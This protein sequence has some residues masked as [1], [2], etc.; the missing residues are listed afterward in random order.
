MIEN[1]PIEKFLYHRGGMMLIDKLLSYTKD[2]VVVEACITRDSIFWQ[3]DG[4]PAVIGIEYA[5]Q[6]VATLSGVRAVLNNEAVKLGLL[7]SGRRYRCKK[8]YFAE[9][10][11]LTIQAIESFNDGRMGAYNCKIMGPDGEEIA[12]VLIN[13]YVPDSLD[14]LR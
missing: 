3:K 2:S 4:I 11:I 12:S 10:E 6:A 14:E 1:E 13:A 8:Q 9:N 7:L 5:A